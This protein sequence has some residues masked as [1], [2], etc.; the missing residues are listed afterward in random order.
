[1]SSLKCQV[2]RHR[3]K[4]DSGSFAL[5]E[6]PSYSGCPRRT[7]SSMWRIGSFSKTQTSEGSSGVD[8][9]VLV[10]DSGGVEGGRGGPLEGDYSQVRAERVR[11]SI[12][13]HEVGPQRKNRHVSKPETAELELYST[14]RD[15]RP[16]VSLAQLFEPPSAGSSQSR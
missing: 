4:R 15:L 11:Q 5:G 3:S 10:Q 12:R 2:R 6:L 1:M 9:G 14:G 13:P 16:G 7:S 8:C